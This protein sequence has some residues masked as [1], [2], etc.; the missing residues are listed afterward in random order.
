MV[1]PGETLYYIPLIEPY[2]INVDL[3]S[4]IITVDW[5]KDF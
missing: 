2:L 4:G 5:D 1:V 3:A